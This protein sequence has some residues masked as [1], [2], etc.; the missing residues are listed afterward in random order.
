VT[1][2]R[3]CINWLYA[4]GYASTRW[5][6][7]GFCTRYAQ[8]QALLALITSQ[9]VA[10]G[11]LVVPLDWTVVK[12]SARS[13][14][15]CIWLSRQELL[16]FAPAQEHTPVPTML[17]A[18]DLAP[19]Y[20][21]HLLKTCRNF[22]SGSRERTCTCHAMSHGNIQTEILEHLQVDT[23]F[24]NGVCQARLEQRQLP[25]LT[26]LLPYTTGGPQRRNQL[27]LA[28]GAHHMDGMH[29]SWPATRVL[30]D[31]DVTS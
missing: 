23:M 19:S 26:A 24:F 27:V 2:N 14:T 3:D 25:A 1:S 9:H 30:V 21:R 15:C 17:H 10:S 5:N 4:G 7:A 13:L 22:E 12:A 16:P 28:D 29:G 11:K 31:L 20:C 8:H 6:E 18:G